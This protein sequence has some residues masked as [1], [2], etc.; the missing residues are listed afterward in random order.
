V[1]K[2]VI[3]IAILMASLLLV[4][5][6]TSRNGH[7]KRKRGCDCP[8]FSEIHVNKSAAVAYPIPTS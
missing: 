3:T 6:A 7:Q 2:I 5:C 1:K 4:S 8:R